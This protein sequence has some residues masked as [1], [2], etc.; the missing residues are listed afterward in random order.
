[1]G[2]QKIN[3][4]RLSRSVIYKNPWVNLYADKVQFP[5]GTIIEK[6][7]VIDFERET[8]AVL[9][10]NETGEFLFIQSY[11]YVTD[12]TEWEIPAGSI[13]KD[14]TIFEAAKRETEEETGYETYQPELIYTYNPMNGI[15][16]KVF[17]IVKCRTSKIVNSFDKSEVIKLKWFSKEETNEMIEKKIIRCGLS[18][19]A[20][21]LNMFGTRGLH[22]K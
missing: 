5:D 14:E 8:V 17:H 6:H 4:R 3:P 21:L 20:L 15:S 11:R 9:L 1:M 13:E 22:V 19:T 16:S 12:S 7:H 2:T 18:L 10:E